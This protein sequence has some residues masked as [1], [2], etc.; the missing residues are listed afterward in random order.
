MVASD[1]AEVPFSDNKENK[2]RPI[3]VLTYYHVS[4]C[5]IYIFIASWQF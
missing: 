3:Y 4:E 2:I 1:L 5:R